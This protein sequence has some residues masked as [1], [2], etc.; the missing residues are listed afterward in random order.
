MAKGKN[1]D[2]LVTIDDVMQGRI[3]AE[4][5]SKLSFEQ[6]LGLLEGVVTAVESGSLPLD[7]AIG[8]YE[9]GTEL[10]QHLRGLLAGAEEKLR[11]LSDEQ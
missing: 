3:A 1:N 10:V 11:M 5:I 6:A 2:T 4:D 7:Q 8:S 9:R